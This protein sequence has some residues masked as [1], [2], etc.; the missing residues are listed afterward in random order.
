MENNYQLSRIH[1]YV[2]GLMS[3]DEMHT[4]ERE[5][6][7]D[8]FLQDA[9][10][11]YKLQQGVDVKQLS[12]LQQRLAARLESN[13]DERNKRFYSWQR[14]AIGMTAGV[15]FIIVCT[16]LLMKYLPQQ[17]KSDLA[18]VEIMH[19]TTW[20]YSISPSANNDAEP[21]NGWDEFKT[22]LIQQIPSENNKL[23]Q[24]NVSFSVDDNGNAVDIKVSGITERQKKFLVDVIQNKYKWKGSK[25]EFSIQMDRINIQ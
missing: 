18:E 17:Q 5:A 15:M 7:D 21:V 10:D 4:L 14:L 6:L 16:L 3:Q 2:H 22:Y 19:D 23:D 9:I 20:E 13:A 24:A 8:P 25:G 12:L 1:N 11:G